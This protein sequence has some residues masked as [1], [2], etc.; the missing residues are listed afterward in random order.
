[1]KIPRPEIIKRFSGS[2]Q[3]SMKFSLLIN[4]NM[5]IIV[6]SYLL[7]EKLSYSAML[8]EEFAIGRNLKSASRD[9]ELSMK[10]K[11]GPRKATHHESMHI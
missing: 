5:P 8:N 1:M 6:F 7:A 9:A 4:M 3:L 2:T 11:S 10:K